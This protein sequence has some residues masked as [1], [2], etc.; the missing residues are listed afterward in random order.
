MSRS[1][2]VLFG[3]VRLERQGLP[4][5]LFI[6]RKIEDRGHRST[7][8]DP[9]VDRLPLLER[10]LKDY[11]PGTA[12]PVLTRLSAT[13]AG[14]DGYVLV[15]AEYNASIPPA[16]SNLMDHFIGEYARRPAAIVCYSAG[17]FGGVRAAVQLRSF[18]A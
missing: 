1:I 7:L 8:I 18:L 5:A 4:A 17:A 11:A 6:K 13:L 12:S 16:L 14:A 10:R 2:V 9:M 15:S 3:S